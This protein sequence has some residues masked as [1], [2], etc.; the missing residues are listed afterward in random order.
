MSYIFLRFP[1]FKDK[2]LTLSYDDGTIYDRK[3]IDI[4]NKNGLKGTF[5]LNSGFFAEKE[6]GFRL[7]KSEALKLYK[8]SGHEVSLHGAKHL[9]LAEVDSA[10]ATNDVLSDR[11]Y[12]EETFGVP[13]QGMAYANGSYN[14]RVVQILKNCGVR[15]ARTTETTERF[16]IP[17]DWLRLPA[18]CHHNHPDLMGL[19]KKFLEENSSYYWSKRQKLFYLWGHS[20]EFNNNDNWQ[21]IEEFAAYVGGRDDVWYATNGEICDYVEAYDRLRFG[22]NGDFVYNPSAI[23]VYL[24]Y[25]DKQYVV[26]AGGTI[27]LVYA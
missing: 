7:T 2:A 22:A 5:N 18:T 27:K 3:L 25:Y 9:S 20:Y 19:A 8:K 10:L 13:V 26:P 21:V 15:Y 12:L 23:S 16:D 24:N 6:G 14:D 4:M 11:K 1:G 17:T